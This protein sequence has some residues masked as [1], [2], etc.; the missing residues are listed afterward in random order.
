M[1]VLLIEED[2]HQSTL[3]GSMLEANEGTRVCV[4]HSDVDAFKKITL[5]GFIPDLIVCDGVEMLYYLSKAVP[6]ASYAILS[7]ANDDVLESAVD[8]AHGCGIEHMNVY[9]TP[10]S[11]SQAEQLINMS[12]NRVAH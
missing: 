10:L 6:N 1:D 3:I 2:L 9:S 4:A 11:P 12:V 7:A 5:Q 8:A